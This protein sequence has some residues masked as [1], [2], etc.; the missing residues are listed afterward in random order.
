MGMITGYGESHWRGYV[1]PFTI[2]GT[3]GQN[4][5]VQSKSA[6]ILKRHGALLINGNSCP[7]LIYDF[8]FKTNGRGEVIEICGENT[9]SLKRVK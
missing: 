8:H 2:E 7:T 4:K 6:K 3:F 1:V 9:L 5:T